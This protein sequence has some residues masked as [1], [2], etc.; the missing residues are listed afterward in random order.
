MERKTNGTNVTNGTVVNGHPIDEVQQDHIAKIEK[1]KIVDDPK[2][3]PSST[4]G[5]VYIKDDLT[6]ARFAILLFS[7]NEKVGA[8]TEVL[9]IFSVSQ[10]LDSNS[11]LKDILSGSRIILRL[12]PNRIM[13][14]ICRISNRDRRNDLQ[15]NTNL[16]S[17]LTQTRAML[18]QLS[19][20]FVARRVT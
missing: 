14:S 19:T 18:A 20:N 7:M 17:K 5:G 8:L 6:K 3:K 13:E 15:T 12:S 11:Q 4:F 1:M 16:L 10:H 2:R 9:K